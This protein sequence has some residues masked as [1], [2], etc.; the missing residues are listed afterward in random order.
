MCI[1]RINIYPKLEVSIR[2]CLEK[3]KKNKRVESC[4]AVS[5]LGMWNLSTFFLRS[6]PNDI[7]IHDNTFDLETS[8]TFNVDVNN[9]NS[10][11][12]EHDSQIDTENSNDN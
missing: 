12:N 11:I 9:A 7:N 1:D 8:N 4:M 2:L 6:T 5:R 10:D 3:W